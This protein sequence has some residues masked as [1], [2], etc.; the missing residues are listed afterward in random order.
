MSYNFKRRINRLN[1][2]Q[3]VKEFK[4]QYNYTDEQLIALCVSV[5]K[6]P[7]LRNKNDVIIN[8]LTKALEKHIDE[9]GQN[10]EEAN[11]VIQ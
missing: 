1:Y 10:G 4:K 2:K 3:V 8:T 11:S 9:R 7:N 5:H 6:K